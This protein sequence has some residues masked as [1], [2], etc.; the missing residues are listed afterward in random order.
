MLNTATD[1]RPEDNESQSI[2]VYENTHKRI[3]HTKLHAQRG[4]VP[5]MKSLPEAEVLPYHEKLASN[6]IHAHEGN[7]IKYSNMERRRAG[8]QRMLIHQL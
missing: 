5:V 1:V 3:V 7:E 2:P 4:A 8:W 6:E